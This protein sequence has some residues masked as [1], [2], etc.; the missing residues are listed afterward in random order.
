VSDV[1]GEQAKGY[2]LSMDDLLAVKNFVSRLSKSIL[3]PQ[4][5]RRLKNLSHTVAEAKKGVKNLFKSFLPKKREEYAAGSSGARYRYDRIESQV[6]LL[7][8]TEFQ[9]GDYESALA[10]YRIARDDFKTDKAGAHFLY[11]QVMVAAC[12]HLSQAPSRTVAGHLEAAIQTFSMECSAHAAA[13]SRCSQPGSGSPTAAPAGAGASASD[14][15]A[16]LFAQLALV[17]ESIYRGQ[18]ASADTFNHGK[19][20][21]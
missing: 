6:L 9:L 19:A 17:L 20:A 21:R 8:E 5:E 11:S 7:A 16:F 18:I 2:R 15:H 1:T 13:Q 4:L 12:S 10:D 14:T 3:V